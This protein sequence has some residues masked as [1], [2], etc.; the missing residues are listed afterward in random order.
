M[1][2]WARGKIRQW[3][4]NQ[5]TRDSIQC[6]I[7]II[8]WPQFVN[9]LFQMSMNVPATPAEMVEHVTTFWIT[10][11]ARVGKVSLD[12]TAKKVQYVPKYFDGLVLDCSNPSALI[13]ELLQSCTRPSIWYE[14]DDDVD[15]DDDDDNDNNDDNDN[16]NSSKHPYSLSLQWHTYFHAWR[17]GWNWATVGINMGS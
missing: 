8:L 17:Q 10:T 9:D 1:V 12:S 5:N 13:M 2:N 6:A 3:N 11:R 16:C 15:Y 4:V 7:R 14:Y